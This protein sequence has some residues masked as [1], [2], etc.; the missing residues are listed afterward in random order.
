MSGSVAD[1]KLS[2][3]Y[4]EVTGAN[5]SLQDMAG[6]ANSAA[7]QAR[8][9][10]AALAGMSGGFMDLSKRTRD[11]QETLR[12]SSG[13][14]QDLVRNLDLA[15]RGIAEVADQTRSIDE[16]TRRLEAFGRVFNTTAAG[17]E[18]FTRSASRLGLS[19]SESVTAL[20]RIQSAMEGITSEGRASRAIFESYGVNVN[21]ATGPSGS[22]DIMRQ[23]L[24]R[25]RSLPQ[26]AQRNR[27][28]AFALGPMGPDTLQSVVDPALLTDE[29]RRRSLEAR[30]RE[31]RMASLNERTV[32]MR[33]ETDRFEARRDELRANYTGGD[34]FEF[35]RRQFE[36]G[37]QEMARLEGYNDAWK[38]D[39]ATAPRTNQTDLAN[40]TLL[41]RGGRYL[42]YM[43]G[44]EASQNSTFIYEQFRRDQNRIGYFPALGNYYSDL[45][46]NFQQEWNAPQ[47]RS[48]VQE[49]QPDHEAL[50]RFLQQGDD[51]A[52]GVRMM[53][54]M[55]G[56]DY[57]SSSVFDPDA[58]AGN[59]RTDQSVRRM[60][61]LAT[62]LRGQLGASQ[63]DVDTISGMPI[64]EV[65]NGQAGVDSRIP[66][67][68]LNAIREKFDTEDRIQ[69]VGRTRQFLDQRERR[70]SQ[71][72]ESGFG[73]GPEMG[74]WQAQLRSIEQAYAGIIDLT[75]R[76]QIIEAETNE[77]LA[78]GA[79]LVQRQRSQ[80]DLDLRTESAALNAATSVDGDAAPDVRNGAALRARMDSR[81]AAAKPGSQMPVAEQ[82]LRGLQ[83]RNLE[84]QN[85]FEVRDQMRDVNTVNNVTR[86]GSDDQIAET[87]RRLQVERELKQEMAQAQASGEQEALRIVQDRI[88]VRMEELRLVEDVAT[89]QT[90][91]ANMDR[92]MRS[93]V[94]IADTYNAITP[95]T[96]GATRLNAQISAARELAPDV[97]AK[98]GPDEANQRAALIRALRTSTDLQDRATAALN[99]ETHEQAMRFA[100]AGGTGDSVLNR[101]MMREAERADI[102]RRNP[103]EEAQRNA[104]REF[105][106]RNRTADSDRFN[107]ILQGFNRQDRNSRIELDQLEGRRP[108]P[109][110]VGPTGP[111]GTTGA[112]GRTFNPVTLPNTDIQ[113]LID[114]QA[115][116]MGIDVNQARTL[117]LIESG[118]NQVRTNRRTGQVETVTSD[119]GARGVFQLMP[120]TAAGL[121]VDPDDVQQN[122]R[123]GLTYWQQQ[124]QRSGGDANGAWIA[125]NQGP[126]SSHFRRW[127]QTGSLENY[128][129]QTM[130]GF[131]IMRENSS[132]TNLP[133]APATS[134]ADGG[135]N[136]TARDAPSPAESGGEA[137]VDARRALYG[138]ARAR[139]TMQVAGMRDG[140]ADI[141]GQEAMLIDRAL[142]TEANQALSSYSRKL[143]E[144]RAAIEDLNEA[145][146]AARGSSFEATMVRARQSTDRDAIGLEDRASEVERTNPELAQRLR[147]R[148]T[149]LRENAE[150]M[151]RGQLR[152]QFESES[153]YRGEQIEDES[154]SI[155]D[156]FTMGRGGAARAAQR[157]RTERSMNDRFGGMMTDE[158]RDKARGQMDQ[159]QQI[160][161]LAEVTQTARQAFQGLGD[162]AG[163][164]LSAIIVHGAD[165]KEVLA[166]LVKQMSSQV[167]SGATSAL[168]NAGMNAITGMVNPQGSKSGGGGSGILGTLFGIGVSAASAY[169]GVPVPG[170]ADMG[171][172]KAGMVPGISKIPSA[173]GNVFERGDLVPFAL[174]G[175]I[176]SPTTFPMTGGRTGLMAEAGPEAIVPLKRGPDGKLGI[177]GGGGGP[178]VV[179][180]QYNGSAQDFGANAQQ[181]AG[182]L[183]AAVR[184]GNKR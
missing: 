89:R 171:A 42:E 51:S 8:S 86:S 76:R 37:N 62:M 150:G 15:K 55:S 111:A 138:G 75:K 61:Q 34:V 140:G 70:S 165:A 173:N 99:K 122:V 159:L 54:R 53:A 71:E 161:E 72:G 66:R 69:I 50:F 95:G 126:N 120:R 134:V 5:R 176:E 135:M 82:L 67:E 13:V 80:S 98:A 79:N 184:R 94:E 45:W 26:S 60:Q 16:A 85:N 38:R 88:R 78:Q 118:G 146:V 97:V 35:I 93:Q 182:N 124:L 108:T 160:Q 106:Q 6:S 22:S 56:L 104:L 110:V 73:I 166:S 3:D 162:S 48:T 130:R 36:S 158:E 163:E 14:L 142:V 44:G 169:A 10:N 151:A 58:T 43:N 117:A 177:A 102:I 167:L 25:W 148:A 30:E 121:G 155:L 123:G 164:A 77:L 127:Q 59:F 52:P 92:R 46:K 132:G 143:L 156:G 1:L 119:A 28:L 33:R 64:E 83:Q 27:D 84:W 68:H 154:G 103:G 149:G 170:G 21:G 87:R 175:V 18:V 178:T 29:Q 39:P 109:G 174:G 136:V 11:L 4:G 7:S 139:A 153:R 115:T 145:M 144:G 19:S 32:G 141:D 17:I 40:A 20:S 12:G 147:G 49:G 131:R 96:G 100:A 179:N 23:F 116:S 168:M 24:E 63:E 2:V 91:G 113:S 31:T 125:Y 128:P 180:F 57:P 90:A 137:P 65:L 129:A 181:I 112:A 74:D 101:R 41:G 9:L 107:G 183:A 152:S 47:Q 105:D 157:R 172:V 81:F 133:N 114:A